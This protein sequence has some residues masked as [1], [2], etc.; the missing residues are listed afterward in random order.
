MTLYRPI[1][2]PRAIF[3]SL[4]LFACSESY[5]SEQ[6]KVLVSEF[7]RTYQ[8]TIDNMPIDTNQSYSLEKLKKINSAALISIAYRWHS[9][10]ASHCSQNA[11][12]KMPTK[13]S[14]YDKLASQQKSATI[15]FSKISDSSRDCHSLVFFDNWSE[16][17]KMISLN[18]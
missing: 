6:T 10:A 11:E 1:E 14:N 17:Q 5:D 3:L 15:T 9:F 2:L 4:L 18:L 13:M 7:E 8:H 16:I 12:P